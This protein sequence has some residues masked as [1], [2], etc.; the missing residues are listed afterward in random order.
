VLD[1][2]ARDLLA[3]DHVIFE[4]GVAIDPSK[5][6]AVLACSSLGEGV[7]KFFGACRLLSPLC[8]ALQHDYSFSDRSIE[9]RSVV[10]LD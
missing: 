9:E 4:H 5:V 2:L 1:L 10:Y 8:E 6:E 7:A 3:R